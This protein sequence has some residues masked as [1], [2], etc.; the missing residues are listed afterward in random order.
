M[1]RINPA[2]ALYFLSSAVLEKG[3]LLTRSGC[4][5]GPKSKC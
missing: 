2:A 3:E 4:M 5:Q 1:V